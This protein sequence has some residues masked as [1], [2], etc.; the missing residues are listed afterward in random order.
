MAFYSIETGAKAV[1]EGE[2]VRD[3]Q[4]SVII[5]GKNNRGKQEARDRW[6]K[7][8]P[9]LARRK[10]KSRRRREDKKEQADVA[11]DV[12]KPTTETDGTQSCATDDTAS[13]SGVSSLV[14]WNR[15]RHGSYQKK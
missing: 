11:F 12:V 14:N 9:E 6:A 8:H 13:A 7:Q 2:D 10:D 5:Q 15:G 4:P 1:Q 3:K